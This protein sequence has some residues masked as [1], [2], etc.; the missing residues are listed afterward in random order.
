MFVIRW[1]QMQFPNDLLERRRAAVPGAVHIRLA[2]IRVPA[3]FVHSIPRGLVMRPIASPQLSRY[4]E[5]QWHGQHCGAR[6]HSTLGDCQRLAIR[7]YESRRTFLAPQIGLG[8]DSELAYLGY[9]TAYLRSDA[10]PPRATL[11]PRTLFF[12]SMMALSAC[13]LT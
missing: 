13:I 2:P 1:G 7:P 11:T 6:G 5:G 9:T 12:R 3:F 4:F 8:S 10:V